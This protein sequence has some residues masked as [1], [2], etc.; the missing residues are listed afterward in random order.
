MAYVVVVCAM[1]NGAA[2]V[3]VGYYLWKYWNEVP[4]M[5]QTSIQDEVR[6]QDDRIEKRQQRA[7]GPSQDGNGTVAADAND[8]GG[9]VSGIRAGRPTRRG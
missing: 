7:A 8:L 5:V 4:Q 9:A 3:G 6:R 2:M 1:L